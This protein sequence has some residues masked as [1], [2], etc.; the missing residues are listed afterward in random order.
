MQIANVNLQNNRCRCRGDE[1]PVAGVCFP[2]IGNFICNF[3]CI[4][5]PSRTLRPEPPRHVQ[6]DLTLCGYPSDKTFGLLQKQ[7]L[8]P[9]MIQSMEILQLPIL[10][11]EE[12]IA[13][14][15]VEKPGAR[16]GGGRP[17]PALRAGR[18]GRSGRRPGR[19]HRGRTRTGHRR[20]AP[21]TRTTSRRLMKMDQEWPDHFE[22]RSRPSRAE[23]EEAGE[24]KLD[25]MANMIARPQTLQDY[26]HDQLGWFELDA[27]LRAMAE[28]IVY[29]LDTNDTCKAGWKTSWA[30]RRRRR[31]W[32][33]P[34]GRWRWWQKLDPP[35]IAARDLRECLLLQLTPACRCSSS[36]RP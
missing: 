7:V 1:A 11:L 9:R 20:G 15:M 36:F 35:G 31:S 34:S 8:A 21:A 19:P 29:N 28:R 17:G 12:R 18:C 6:G 25:A 32:R 26:L 23:Q 14:E 33:W 3:H 30:R 13:Q 22:E 4:L 16:S 24:R 10:A 2:V 5:V 27:P